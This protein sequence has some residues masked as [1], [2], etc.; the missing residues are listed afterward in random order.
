MKIFAAM[1]LAALPFGNLPPQA[2]AAPASEQQT[3][4][5]R[6]R[7]ESS[8]SGAFYP[9]TGATHPQT[10]RTKKTNRL[11]ISKQTRR[12]HQRKNKR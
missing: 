12:K 5:R 9:K 6:V 7:R 1:M 2:G 10:R 4:R 11:R 3:S 8:T